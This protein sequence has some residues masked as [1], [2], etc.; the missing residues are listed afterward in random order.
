LFL[1]LSKR[2]TAKLYAN[3]CKLTTFRLF[4]LKCPHTSS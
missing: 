2:E 4:A 1:I 3:G